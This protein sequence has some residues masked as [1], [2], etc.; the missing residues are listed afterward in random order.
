M[1]GDDDSGSDDT[2]VTAAVLEDKA[3]ADKTVTYSESEKNVFATN[4]NEYVSAVNEG[5]EKINYEMQ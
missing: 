3:F 2:E 1:L 4:V 5:N